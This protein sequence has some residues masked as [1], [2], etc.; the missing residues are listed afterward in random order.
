MNM[1]NIG[2][3]VMRANLRPMEVDLLF[4]KIKTAIGTIIRINDKYEIW[5]EWPNGE[6]CI[7]HHKQGE[8][9]KY[10]L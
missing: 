8:I 9:K 6:T 2:D 1:F 5:W 10:E 7:T 4:P 3:K